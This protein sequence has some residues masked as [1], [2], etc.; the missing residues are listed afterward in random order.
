M[1][2][3]RKEHKL[4]GLDFIIHWFLNHSGNFGFGGN[5]LYVTLLKEWTNEYNE[6]TNECNEWTNIY[7]H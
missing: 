6:W 1:E 2:R 4:I 3:R 5:F 7:K